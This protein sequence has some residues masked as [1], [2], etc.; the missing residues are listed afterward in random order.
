MKKI[1]GVSP[2]NIYYSKPMHNETSKN[3]EAGILMNKKEHFTY[4]LMSVFHSL[5][6][7]DHKMKNITSNIKD[8]ELNLMIQQN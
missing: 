8:T 5:A 4:F 3:D 7:H 6:V 1:E 2:D